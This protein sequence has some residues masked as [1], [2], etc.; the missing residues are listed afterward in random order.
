MHCLTKTLLASLALLGAGCGSTSSDEAT[1]LTVTIES[2]NNI[3]SENGVLELSAGTLTVESVSL[4]AGAETVPLVGPVTVDLSK[5]VQELPLRGPVPTGMFSGLRIVFAPPASG[6]SMMDVD[7]RAAETGEMVRAIS[8]LTVGGDTTFPEGPRLVG[9]SSRVELHIL[10]QGMFFYLAP[11]TDAVDGV[12]R[13]NEA[14]QDFLTMDLVG[15][16]D[17]RVSSAE[18]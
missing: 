7:L 13:A 3:V 11:L 1:T 10:M 6:A 14:H 18:P 4:I 2:Q 15:M 5:P 17:L 9:E 8:N 16:F 12:F